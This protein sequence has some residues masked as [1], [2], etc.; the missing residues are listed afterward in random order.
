MTA[1][2]MPGC[3]VRLNISWSINVQSSPFGITKVSG[4]LGAE[5]GVL[6]GN[7]ELSIRSCPWS[8]WALV[9]YLCICG[10]VESPFS[11]CCT[12][13]VICYMSSGMTCGLRSDRGLTDHPGWSEILPVGTTLGGGSGDTSGVAFR[14]YILG[15]GLG[16][17]CF[18]GNLFVVGVTCGGTAMLKISE[19]F[20][21]AA[22]YL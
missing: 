19:I 12:E 2:I 9:L 22:V 20:L 21:K 10:T 11:F 16:A 17:F 8:Q 14:V 7:I 13:G 6:V 15:G 5:V 3:R 1:F 18:G 4:L